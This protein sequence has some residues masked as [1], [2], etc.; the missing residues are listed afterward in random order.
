[1]YAGI[2]NKVF[3]IFNLPMVIIAGTLLPVSFLLGNYNIKMFHFLS[4][5]IIVLLL[6]SIAIVTISSSDINK[7]PWFRFLGVC[8][9]VVVLFELFH[10]MFSEELLIFGGT[11]H[12]ISYFFDIAESYVASFAV[13]IFICLCHRNCNTLKVTYYFFIIPVALLIMI[14]LNLMPFL[15]SPNSYGFNTVGEFSIIC[16]NIL[17]LIVIHLRKS[18]FSLDIRCYIGMALI[19]D[20]YSKIF[21]IFNWQHYN[22]SY[23]LYLYFKAMGMYMI[24]AIILRKTLLQP[25]GMMNEE[26]YKQNLELI[27]SQ[28]LIK[29]RERLYRKVIEKIPAP[30]YLSK[31]GRIEFVNNSM[32]SL[33]KA[34]SP[35]A[36]IGMDV[37][38][39]VHHSSLNQ[40]L[41][42]VSEAKDDNPVI[43][44]PEKIVD[45]NNNILDVEF[46]C[47][48]VESSNGYFRMVLFTDMTA[49]KKSESMAAALEEA[50][51]N[52]RLYSEYFANLS[53][54]F[55][56]PINVI[57][58]SSQMISLYSDKGSIEKIVN[59]NN[60]I[61]QNCYRISKL[62]NNIIDSSRINEGFYRINP[63]MVDF[64]SLVEDTVASVSPFIQDHD[65]EII[66]DTEVE[67]LPLYCDPDK[68]ERIILNLLSNAVKYKKDGAGNIEVN[69]YILDN[70]MVEISVK[71]NGKGIPKEKVEILFSRF[72]KVDKSFTR[73]QEGSGLG[74]CIVKSLVE[75]H[76]GVIS[77]HSEVN[78]G[79]DFR[80]KLPIINSGEPLYEDRVIKTKSIDEKVR[81]EFSD[82][83]L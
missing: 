8:F 79:S 52:E 59:Y 25:V 19:F 44:F 2:K 39:L 80:I 73:N 78:V 31:E 48:P 74:L 50:K 55:R 65:V 23:I 56:T 54:E 10:I 36:L 46:T 76:K 18:D 28:N 33:L 30:I 68:I 34:D 72:M 32:V 45:F 57:Y 16:L 81:I 17:A 51:E 60:I 13:L 49:V 53:H 66:F 62:V 6:F 1:M 11:N 63:V 14:E 64:I 15:L 12:S 7:N 71:D 61:K 70:D 20:I 26:L 38:S 24:Y 47:L 27:A 40:I 83:F 67:E 69:I 77:V 29:E 58:S 42:A 5:I 3:D 75:L 9:S 41:K 37:Q 22:I 35:E 4:E 21:L 43:A 82:V